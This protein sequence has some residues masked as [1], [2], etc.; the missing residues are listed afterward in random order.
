MK[1]MIA[2]FAAV[3]ALLASVNAQVATPVGS[4]GGSSQGVVIEGNA[5]AIARSL[6]RSKADHYT[7]YCSYNLTSTASEGKGNG[8]VWMQ[9]VADKDLRITSLTVNGTNIVLD[10]P[11][12]GIPLPTNGI[13]YSMDIWIN[14]VNKSGFAR[15]NGSFYAQLYRLSDP[16]IIQ[17]DVPE[18]TMSQD[19]ALPD[20]I[21]GN[22][23]AVKA[24]NPDSDWIYGNYDGATQTLRLQMDAEAGPIDYVVYNWRT[25]EKI[26]SGTAVPFEGSHVNE[27]APMNVAYKD[28]IVEAE[29]PGEWIQRSIYIQT[30]QFDS[31]IVTST[32]TVMGKVII[33]DLGGSILGL[34]V[35]LMN[36]GLNRE[37][38][39]IRVKKWQ[40]TDGILPIVP[41]SF[42]S[43][44]YAWFSD[45]ST[46]GKV[47][48][49]II[50]KVKVPAGFRFNILVANF[51]FGPRG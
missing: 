7:G 36:N 32:G 26:G 37:D 41:V 15:A 47:I 3:M 42:D 44:A 39:D 12:A 14:Q 34:G 46:L 18:V 33:T 43:D 29:L 25:G 23:V 28:N 45:D 16:V 1:K 31:P 20:G 11:I 6:L 51:K 40:S 21:D 35:D 17:L 8:D 50:P 48:L 13:A 9:F 5:E 22:D 30:L 24:A 2:M 4:G 49:E 27:L 19:F 10:G 38:L